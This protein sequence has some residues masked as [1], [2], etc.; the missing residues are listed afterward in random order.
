[1]ASVTVTVDD[2]VARWP[3][4]SALTDE[5]ETRYLETQITDAVDDADSRW[6]AQIES[7]LTSGALKPGRYKRIIADAVFRVIKNPDGFT[8][9]NNGSYGYGRNQSVA[10]GSLL[11]TPDDEELLTG[12]IPGSFVPS[13]VALRLDRGWS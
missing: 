9:E 4:G 3:E 7:R 1:M 2:L 6:S 8:S 11:F 10:S 12:V 5:F 13:T